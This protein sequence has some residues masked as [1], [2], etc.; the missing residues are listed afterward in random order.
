M[1]LAVMA[2][3]LLAAGC[4]SSGSGDLAVSGEI[5]DQEAAPDADAAPADGMPDGM[6]DGMV[7]GA[8][9]PEPTATPEPEPTATPEPE[10]EPTPTPEP[11][12]A[13]PIE[14][15]DPLPPGAPGD[16]ISAESL[17][18][19][20]D[21]V[22]YRVLYHSQALDGRD[23][24]V[25]GYV[26]APAGEPPEGGWPVI[27]WAHGTTGMADACAPSNDVAGDVF[28]WQGVTEQGYVMAATDYE[29]LGTPGLHPYIVGESE[30]RGV[31]DIVR[32]L[33][34]LD[35]VNASE[36]V[37][38]WGHS[39]GGHAAMF[40]GQI[41]PEWAP[42]LDLVG[43]VAGAPPS[44]FPL[45]SAF[46]QGSP[47][48]GYIVMTAAALA[49][50]YPQLDLADVLTPEALEL[51]AV[52]DE[53]CT[54]EVFEVFNPLAYDD[55]AAVPDPFGLEGWGEVLVANDTNQQPMPVPTIILQGG[56]DEQI[57][58]VSSG[59]LF[60]QQC[61]LDGTVSMERTIYEG[62]DHA[63]VVPEYADDMFAWLADRFASVPPISQC[64]AEA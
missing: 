15:P 24:A 12:V 19:G 55:I 62:F 33:D 20:P 9:E 38:V 46:L 64:P 23:I 59:L 52:L 48:Q 51:A 29:G 14:V 4:S 57:P 39:Q 10:P 54:G 44:Q 43:V 28:L 31:L 30:G 17:D 49:A 60:E 13:G 37:A 3:G 34:E 32:V 25:S 40:A 8:A 7:D 2:M 21:V 63:G 45:L 5:P 1:L 50:A 22:G 27:S 47:F 61:A 42:E 26:V 53:G 58:V 18:L 6:V 35:G 56:D 41:W 16:L 11:E 36:R